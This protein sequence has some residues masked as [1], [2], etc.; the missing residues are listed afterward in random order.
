M[1][2]AMGHNETSVYFSPGDIKSVSLSTARTTGAHSVAAP[3]TARNTDAPA[4]QDEC[5]DADKTLAQHETARH[6]DQRD[7]ITPSLGLPTSSPCRFNYSTH[8]PCQGKRWRVQEAD[9]ECNPRWYVFC[10]LRLSLCTACLH[11]GD[12]AKDNCKDDHERAALLG[13]ASIPYSTE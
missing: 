9:G 1:S 8:Q 13:K 4:P 12:K 6:H 2:H 7:V 10:N 3:P 11:G 5:D